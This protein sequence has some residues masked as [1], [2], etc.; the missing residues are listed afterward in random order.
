MQFLYHV[1]QLQNVDNIVYNSQYMSIS[2][3]I[4]RVCSQLG[5]ECS[6]IQ[7]VTWTVFIVTNFFKT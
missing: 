7:K 2:T 1:E 5:L 6:I 4:Y 3:R